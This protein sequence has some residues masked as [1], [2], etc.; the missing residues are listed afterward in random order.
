[1]GNSPRYEAGNIGLIVHRYAIAATRYKRP[2]VAHAL[3]KT[4]RFSRSGLHQNRRSVAGGLR[5]LRP[6][7]RIYPRISTTITTSAIHAAHKTKTAAQSG[8]CKNSP[9]LIAMRSFILQDSRCVFIYQRLL[10][11]TMRSPW[12]AF[13]TWVSWRPWT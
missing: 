8:M 5:A 4:G 2:I 13:Q 11:P 10:T 1:M 7:S 6:Y 3:A 9:T 12:V